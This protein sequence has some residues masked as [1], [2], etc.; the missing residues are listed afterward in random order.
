V[1]RKPK[2]SVVQ[3]LQLPGVAKMQATNI[4]AARTGCH[5]GSA[6]I[7]SGMGVAHQVRWESWMRHRRGSSGWTDAA[8]GAGWARVKGAMFGGRAHGTCV[9]TDATPGH[10]S[11]RNTFIYRQ[12]PGPCWL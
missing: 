12:H 11:A 3:L 2:T 6:R 4:G 9:R 5:G 10:L 7:G 8:S 1:W